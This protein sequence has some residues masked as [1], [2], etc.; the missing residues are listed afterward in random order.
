MTT[1][2]EVEIYR[3][4]PPLEPIFAIRYAVFVEGQ[5]VSESEEMDGRDEA[6]IQFLARDGD[7]AVGTARLREPD[8]G[9]GKVERVAVLD[10]YRGDGW[11]RRIMETVEAVARDE[12]IERLVLHGQTAVEEFY[13]DLG[14]ETTSDVFV[15]ADI[16]HVA[17][18][19]D[20]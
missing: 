7:T 3:D 8:P 11:G 6:A 2:T 12:G 5:G 13:H 20:L 4:D 17:M 19:K 15:E 1:D 18:E 9:V 10:D 16:P 14:Y